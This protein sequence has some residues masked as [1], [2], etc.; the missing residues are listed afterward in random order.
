MLPNLNAPGIFDTVKKENF[1]AFYP[2]ILR[3]A[4]NR[5]TALK[6]MDNFVRKNLSAGQKQK[7]TDREKNFTRRSSYTN[8]HSLSSAS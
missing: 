3:Q 2:V 5:L 4:V 1:F 8:A 6:R 7:K